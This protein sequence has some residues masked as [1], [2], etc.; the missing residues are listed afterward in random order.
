MQKLFNYDDWFQSYARLNVINN[1]NANVRN[2]GSKISMKNCTYSLVTNSNYY[3]ISMKFCV[4]VGV[5]V[6]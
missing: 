5:Y 3:P 2:P 6:F 4:G 1:E